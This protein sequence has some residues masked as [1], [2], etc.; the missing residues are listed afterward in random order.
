VGDEFT[1]FFDDHYEPI[2]RSLTLVFGD[3]PRAEDAAQVGFERAYRKW[4]IVGSLDRPATWVYVVALRDARRQL[5]REDRRPR[6]DLELDAVGFDDASATGMDI[7]ASLATLPL[8]QRT[9]VVL[10]YLGGLS[11]AEVATAMGC[12]EGTVKATLHHA[13]ARLRVD[14]TDEESLRDDNGVVSDAT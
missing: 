4:R 10:R 7:R 8:R 11:G 1:R 9:A 6:P 13:L 12:T 2:V 14:L 5:Q 3:R